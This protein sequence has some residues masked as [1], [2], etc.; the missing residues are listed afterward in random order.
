[1]QVFK[2]NMDDI[3]KSIVPV[4]TKVKPSDE[5]F[6]IDLLRNQVKGILDNLLENYSLQTLSLS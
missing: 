1:M 5:E 2:G 4:L 3:S 6:H